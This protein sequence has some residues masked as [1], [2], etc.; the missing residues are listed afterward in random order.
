MQSP[1]TA[2]GSPPPGYSV[3]V[4][5]GHEVTPEVT[6]PIGNRTSIGNRLTSTV[7]AVTAVT[8]I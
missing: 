5:G 6:V 1:N 3:C 2:I 7:T 4:V 8:D